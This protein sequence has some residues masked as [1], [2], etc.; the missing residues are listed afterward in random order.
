MKL[1]IFIL[2]L[3][4]VGG[5][6]PAVNAAD[7]AFD[8]RI[9]TYTINNQS[10]LYRNSRLAYKLAPL[11]S[12]FE[13]LKPVSIRIE[14]EVIDGVGITGSLSNYRISGHA[15]YKVNLDNNLSVSPWAGAGLSGSS[16]DSRVISVDAGLDA[17]YKISDTFSIPI[18]G[19]AIFFSDSTIINYLGGVG[20]KLMDWLSVDGLFAGTLSLP[21]SVNNI[22]FGGRLNILF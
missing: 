22:G 7:F 8:T 18:G 12:S 21:G 3:V 13:F 15:L 1:K 11:L 17:C 20:V 14:H 2:A 16:S 6:L 10:K 5:L 4:V 9:G 19:E